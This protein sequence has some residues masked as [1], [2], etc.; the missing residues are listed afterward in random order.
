MIGVFLFCECIH[1]IDE[2]LARVAR[3]IKFIII[4]KIGIMNVEDHKR[5][6]GEKGNMEKEED[7]EEGK[8]NN[9]SNTTQGTSGCAKWRDKEHK[10]KEEEE[11]K[12]GGERTIIVHNCVEGPDMADSQED[13]EEYPFTRIF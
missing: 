10:E 9:T 2:Y 13:D 4:L 6:K 7:E 8:R 12:G 11:S 1:K 5:E 3:N